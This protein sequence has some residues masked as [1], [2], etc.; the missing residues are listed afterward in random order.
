MESEWRRAVGLVGWTGPQV[1]A[2]GILVSGLK[3]A[4]LNTP[5]HIGGFTIGYVMQIESG[6]I[7][8]GTLGAL[9]VTD[10]RQ[11]QGFLFTL[12]GRF[13]YGFAVVPD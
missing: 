10:P 12:T 11:V 3:A 2:P 7:V 13:P 9:D 8:S 6:G 4:R 1:Y 5:L